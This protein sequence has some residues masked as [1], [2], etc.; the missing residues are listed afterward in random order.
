MS[1][2]P[3][4]WS[5]FPTCL[6][7]NSKNLFLSLFFVIKL[8][9]E[10]VENEIKIK[11]N[12]RKY[13]A[14]KAI[15]CAMTTHANKLE[16]EVITNHYGFCL[17]LFEKFSFYVP[18]Y[19]SPLCWH[20]YREQR[21]KPLITP[22]DTCQKISL[23]GRLVWRHAREREEWNVFVFLSPPDFLKRPKRLLRRRQ[24]YLLPVYTTTFK[25][26]EMTTRMTTLLTMLLAWFVCLSTF[27]SFSRHIISKAIYTIHVYICMCC[28]TFYFAS[29]ILIL[30]LHD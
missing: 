5:P 28:V 20:V 29:L 27:H 3:F 13:R 4:L 12:E 7:F 26:P 16:Y 23:N 14:S 11:G 2:S 15:C 30:L 9:D 8:C 24:T 21:E 6:P 1:S 17:C 22:S 19:I 10:R 25:S 18:L